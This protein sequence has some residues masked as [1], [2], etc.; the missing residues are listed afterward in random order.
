M[1]KN[2]K[3]MLLAAVGSMLALAAVVFAEGN[4]TGNEDG[5]VTDNETGLMWQQQPRVNFASDWSGALSECESLALAG[6]DDWR[7]PNVKELQSIVDHSRTSPAW[8]TDYFLGDSW[9]SYYFWTSTTTARDSDQAW[10]VCFA[11]GKLY[12]VV[13]SNSY[14]VRCV[15]SGLA[16]GR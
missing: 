9:L 4:F 15:R 11:N 2:G 3:R 10:M 12:D 13:K 14:R 8:S 1:A 5:T 6:Y 7:L 16:E